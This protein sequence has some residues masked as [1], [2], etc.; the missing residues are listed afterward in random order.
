MKFDY[1]FAMDRSNKE[2]ILDL[3]RNQKDVNKV[4]LFLNLTHPSE[5]KSVPDP[6]YGG[7]EGFEN[8]FHLLDNA[9]SKF[10][11]QLTHEQ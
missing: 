8:V 2:N 7:E 6:Y 3:A 5:N 1:I 4:E 11:D 10:I 9:C